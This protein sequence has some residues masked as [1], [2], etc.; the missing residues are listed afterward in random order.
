MGVETEKAKDKQTYTGSLED[1]RLALEEMLNSD[2]TK[3]TTRKAAAD[4]LITL[5]KYR[6]EI[7]QQDEPDRPP[8][9]FTPEFVARVVEYMK[10]T[11]GKGGLIDA[12]AE[13]LAGASFEL[14]QEGNG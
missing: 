2:E 8:E 14:S 9:W 1:I 3:E 7:G 13:G 11:F 6:R 10:E 12:E 4:S 5:D